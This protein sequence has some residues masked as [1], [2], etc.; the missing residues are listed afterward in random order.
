MVFYAILNAI[1]KWHKTIFA[2]Q[3]VDTQPLYANLQTWMM[4]LEFTWCVEWWECKILIVRTIVSELG[5][6]N[7][8]GV[9]S[10]DW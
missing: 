3:N 9:A 5:W 2:L 10:Y 1:F 6:V 8:A 4:S 7:L